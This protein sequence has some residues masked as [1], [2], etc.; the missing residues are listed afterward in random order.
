[1]E[2]A[3]KLANSKVPA[4]RERG[5]AVLAEGVVELGKPVPENPTRTKL[6]NLIEKDSVFLL[7]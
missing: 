1:M 5:L 3:Y 6:K 2:I 4:R 7:G